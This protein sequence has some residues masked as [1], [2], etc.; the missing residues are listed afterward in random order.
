MFWREGKGTDKGS[1]HGPAKILMTEDRNLLWLSHLTRLYRCAPE[2]VRQLSEDEARSISDTDRKLVELP[3]RSGSGVFQYQEL[4][5]QEG[6][7]AMIPHEPHTANNIPNNSPSH[8]PDTIILENSQQVTPP[9]NATGPP[10]IGQPDTEPGI[11]GGRSMDPL[12]PTDDTP[13][14]EE[15]SWNIPVPDAHDDELVIMKEKSDFWEIHKD[16]LIRHHVIPRISVFFPDDDN[17]CPV[18]VPELGDMRITSGT[19]ASGSSFE[20]QEQ[21]RDNVEGLDRTHCVCNSEFQ[22]VSEDTMSNER[23][24]ES[25]RIPR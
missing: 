2:H 4:S 18:P 5:S 21:W 14:A 12:T 3:Q 25:S 1:W 19:Y 6:P 11:L 23:V 9:E 17:G 8:E 10:S 20:R 24:S 15:P 7:P 22:R 13:A 16:Q